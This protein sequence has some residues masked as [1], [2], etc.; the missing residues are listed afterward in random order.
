MRRDVLLR[1][2]ERGLLA[3][4]GVLAVW[5]AVV[6]IEARYTNNLPVPSAKPAPSLPGDTGSPAPTPSRGAWLA[7]IEAPSVDMSATVLE[8]TDDG[9]LSRGAGHIEETPIPGQPG[10]VGIAGHRDTV[11][12][13]LR[14]IHVGDALNV[15][16]DLNW[17]ER[18]VP[19]GIQGVEMTSVEREQ[20]AGS[21]ERSLWEQSVQAVISG[22]ESAF[23]VRVAIQGDGERL[24]H[25]TAL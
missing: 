5:C 15:S 10:N 14:H 11:F 20:G 25:A 21:R 7:R 24:R 12:R 1:W 17:F 22:F 19:C 13:P 18:I 6:L 2:L 23:G 16:V 9:T 8:G 4:G 3:I